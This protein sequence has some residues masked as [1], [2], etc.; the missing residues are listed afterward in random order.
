M[1]QTGKNIITSKLVKTADEVT[2]DRVKTRHKVGG[3]KTKGKDLYKSRMSSK[4]VRE[5]L[6]KFCDHF[7]D[8]GYNP[9]MNGSRNL[10]LRSENSLED[11]DEVFY[12]HNMKVFMSYVMARPIWTMAQ[13]G[14]RVNKF[15]LKKIIT[16]E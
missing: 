13:K 3:R 2:R 6:Q 14:F 12:F 5:S 1:N 15:F 7:L 9:S 11:N 16:N 4:P 8:F 10:I